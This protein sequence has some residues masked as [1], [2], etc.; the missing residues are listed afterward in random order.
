ME[1]SSEKKTSAERIRALRKWRKEVGTSF[2]EQENARISA[3]W[4]SQRKTMNIDQLKEHHKK[5]AEHVRLF[6]LHKKLRQQDI[7]ESLPVKSGKG[8]KTPQS[9][10]KA[11]R[12]LDNNLP[13]SPTK[14]RAVVNGLA[15]W[16][17]LE[18]SPKITHNHG[19][20]INQ[21]FTEE[22]KKLITD[23]YV[24][25]DVVHTMPGMHDE[26]TVWE[27][28]IKSKCRKYYLIMF[29]KEVYELFKQSYP[30]IT[31]GFSKFASLRPANV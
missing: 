28:G 6:L 20:R 11:I 24:N 9:L 4:K 12:K 25:T 23:F 2:Q 3:L 27:N 29:L 15:K 18:L 7:I 16:V 17:G 26:M 8:F 22:N 1:T 5:V 13:K 19:Q 14:Q 30:D 10:G 21:R 31:V